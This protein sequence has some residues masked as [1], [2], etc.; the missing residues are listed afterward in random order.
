MPPN[1][2]A[3][4]GRSTSAAIP[5][6]D[7]WQRCWRLSDETW[8]KQ[9][10]HG[11]TKDIRGVIGIS[12]VYRV[13]DFDKTFT[14][15]SSSGF[16]KVNL[17]IRPSAIVFGEDPEV[18]KQASPYNHV[19]PGLP[20]F[21]LLNAG[22]DYP[23][24]RRQTKDFAAALK[25]NQVEVET[26]VIPWRTHETLVFDIGNLTAEPACVEAVVKFIQKNG[27]K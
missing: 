19:R 17:D 25:K 11:A 9:V 13:D 12:G 24:L 23:A 10:G 1:M 3:I 27:G 14:T 18:V 26:M 6:A 7:I 16:L 22:F 15:A 2:A 5:R 4:H 21:L 8:L 20:P